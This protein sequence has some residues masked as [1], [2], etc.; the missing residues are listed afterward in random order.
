VTRPPERSAGILLYRFR[1]TGPEV[2]LVHPGGPFWANKD[3][4]AWSMPKGVCEPGEDMAAAAR[5]EFAEEVGVVPEGPLVPLGE[6]RQSSG[7]LVTAFA[8][9]GDVDP[10]ALISNAFEMEWPPRSGRQ[11]HFPEVDRAEWS[12]LEVA[13]HRI[14]KGQRPIIDALERLLAG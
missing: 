12:S 8:L 13:R 14:H 7:K 6:F 10:A 5:R 11:Q 4:A 3:E 1:A 9:E 2:L